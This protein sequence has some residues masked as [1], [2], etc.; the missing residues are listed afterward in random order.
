HRE[1]D[2]INQRPAGDEQQRRGDEIR[3]EGTALLL[4]KSGRDEQPEL[5]RDEGKGQAE[6]RPERHAQIGEKRLGQVGVDQMP[7]DLVGERRCQGR[8]KKIVDVLAEIPAR[9]KSDQEGNRGIEQPLSQLDQMFEQRHL[10][11]FELLAGLGHRASFL[12]DASDVE[13]SASPDFWVAGSAGGGAAFLSGADAGVSAGF[14]SGLGASARRWGSSGGASACS[15]SPLGSMVF[16][17][18][19]SKLN[20][21]ALSRF[22]FTS[23]S[24]ASRTICSRLF[25]NSRAMPRALRTQIPAVLS[26]RGR[27]F[28]PMT[29]NATTAISASSDQAKSNMGRRFNHR[30]RAAQALP[31]LPP[32]PSCPLRSPPRA[33]SAAIRQDV[34]PRAGRIPAVR[35]SG[36]RRAAPPCPADRRSRTV[37][38]AAGRPRW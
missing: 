22:F 8:G 6:S 34:R 36:R 9:G 5:G 13:A 23:S 20:P 17:T 33:G 27:S 19:S 14:S 4:V 21:A 30:C 29:I 26:T 2:E 11:F 7:P 1:D 12:P 25:W 3:Q 15:I 28:G 37:R 10:A 32:P 18:S 31:P 24:S 16:F 38:N 35:R